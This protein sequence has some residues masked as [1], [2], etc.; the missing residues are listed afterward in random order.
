VSTIYLVPWFDIGRLL[1]QNERLLQ[2]IAKFDYA[3]YKEV[4]ADDM[5]G[6]ELGLNGEV[7][8]G[9]IFHR[10]YLDGTGDRIIVNFISEDAAVIS[11]IRLDQVLLETR[12]DY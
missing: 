7:R 2:S 1:A 4:T 3:S 6:I 5:L 11:Y 8:S 12:I 9:K 10:D